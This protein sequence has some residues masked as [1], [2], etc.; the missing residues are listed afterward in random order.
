MTLPAGTISLSEVNVELGLSAT[1]QISL[2]DAAV[3]TLAGVASGAIGMTDL[4]GKSNVFAFTISSNQVDANLRSLA[5]SAGWNGTSA[6]QATV[7]ADVWISGSVAANS[8]AAITING[9]FPA[10]VTLINNGTIAGRGGNGG[11]G[12]TEPGFAGA[13][14]AGGCALLA[15]VGVTIQNNGT[16][17][18]GGGGGGGG[19]YNLVSAS[20]NMGEDSCR[21]EAGGGGGGGGRSNA[22]YNAS[23]GAAGGST[24]NAGTSCPTTQAQAGGTGTSSGPGAGGAG[25]FTGNT[26]CICTA[27]RNVVGGAGGSGGAWGTAGATGGTTPDRAGAAGGAAGQAVSGNSN[28]TWTAFGTRSGP[29]V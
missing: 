27:C 14:T 3:R 18:G 12:A 1:A 17:A 9:S 2:N 8:T 15:S 10:G 6:V 7:N 16:I 4:Q 25:A 24:F 26:A 23:G 28:I 21:I 13:G 20:C 11:A 29:I 19:G 5:I 22:S